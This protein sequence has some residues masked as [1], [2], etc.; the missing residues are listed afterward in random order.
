MES[1]KMF[2]AWLDPMQTVEKVCRR[3]KSD[4]VR[5]AL[6]DYPWKLKMFLI[7]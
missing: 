5:N 2:A 7:R 3:D 4:D 6:F 1:R